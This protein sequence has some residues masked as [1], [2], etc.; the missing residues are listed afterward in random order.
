ME[1]AAVR[2]LALLGLTAVAASA[3]LLCAG[4]LVAALDGAL[5]K[6][7]RL[8]IVPR[9]VAVLMAAVATVEAQKKCSN[10]GMSEC[11]NIGMSESSNEKKND[12]LS[13][14][15]HSNIQTLFFALTS[16]YE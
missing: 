16:Y 12:S 3:V 4:P 2:I 11:S 1:S 8:G 10:V 14:F 15:K 6:W 7:R 9:V 13:T 5:Q